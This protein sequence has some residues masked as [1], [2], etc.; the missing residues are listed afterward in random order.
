MNILVECGYYNQAHKVYMRMK[1]KRVVPDVYSFT[2]RIKSFC[3]TSRP[4]AALRLLNN[5]P[6][7]GCEVNAV[8]YCTVV[9]GLFQENFELEAFELFDK[10]LRLGIVPDIPTFNKLL[11]TLCKKGNVRGCE[12]LL[13]KVFKRGVSPNLFTFNIFIQG[14][15]R[16]GLIHEASRIMDGVTKAGLVPD[17]VTYNTLICGLCKN[18]K[19]VEAECYLHQMVNLGYEPDAFT[20]N[21]IISGYCKLSRA[22]DAHKI[23]N[24]AIYKGFKPDEFTYCSLINGFC[25]EGDIERSVNM[26]T[27]IGERLKP[28]DYYLQHTN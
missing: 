3:R 8:A 11:H 7:Q 26:F 24:D 25:Q 18:N 23:L 9:G 15:S 13:D 2:I 14:F 12:R 16:R 17:L 5:I 4:H 6:T 21:T 22:T 10:M 28:Y 1:D 20:Y 27:S 19:V